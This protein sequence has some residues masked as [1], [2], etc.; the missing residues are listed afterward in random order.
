[1][2]A[3]LLWS[4]SVGTLRAVSEQLGPTRGAAVLFT[5]SAALLASFGRRTPLRALPRRYLILG[6]LLFAGYEACRHRSSR[7]TPTPC[8][9]DSWTHNLRSS[10]RARSSAARDAL[11]SALGRS[12]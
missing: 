8:E 12:S 2:V 10:H 9:R 1:L 3:I 7:P 5:L 4:T 6:G 11:S